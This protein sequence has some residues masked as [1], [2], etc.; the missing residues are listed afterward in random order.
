MIF[1]SFSNSNKSPKITATEKF[2]NVVCKYQ[3]V[4][5]ILQEIVFFLNVDMVK[6]SR[7]KKIY[8]CFV[9]FF[10]GIVVFDTREASD[11]LL[12]FLSKICTKVHNR[13]TLI[14]L[15]IC[16]PECTLYPNVLSLY[17]KIANALTF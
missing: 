14:H 16:T 8:F 7:N 11:S 4:C 3:C 1:D 9:T 2:C 17:S 5:T 12:F 15:S 10:S 13:R 6:L